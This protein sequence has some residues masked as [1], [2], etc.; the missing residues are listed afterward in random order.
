MAGAGGSGRGVPAETSCL[1]GPTIP[2]HLRPRLLPQETKIVLAENK[3]L[4]L[5]TG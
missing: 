5:P 3:H 4:A 2:L 1:A